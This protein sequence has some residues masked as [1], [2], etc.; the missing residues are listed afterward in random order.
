[1]WQLN[2]S[3][4]F[5]RVSYSYGMTSGLTVDGGVLV[6]YNSVQPYFSSNFLQF[7]SCFT[8]VS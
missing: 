1:M 6:F 5:N 4:F 2:V 8:L 7:I 3:A